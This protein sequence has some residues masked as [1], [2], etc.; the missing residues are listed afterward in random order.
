MAAIDL[1][2]DPDYDVAPGETLR[3]TLTAL[4]MTQIELATRTGLSLKHVNQIIQGVAP[5][6]PDTAL[7][8]EKTTGVHA[9][10]WNSLEA[11]YR[12]HVLRAE[13]REALLKEA[14]WLKELPV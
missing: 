9:R 11:S 6:T 3:D 2:F 7:L 1:V 5:V 10:M 8:L 4:E 13:S 12:E 14:D